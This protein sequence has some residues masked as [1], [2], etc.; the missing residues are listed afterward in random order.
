M[1]K[2]YLDKNPDKGRLEIFDI[3]GRLVY[4]MHLPQWSTIQMVSL[5]ENIANGIFQ[6]MIT[7]KNVIVS[8]KIVIIKN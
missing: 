2:S 1:L 6:C 4:E 5:P 7:T 3:N 8:K